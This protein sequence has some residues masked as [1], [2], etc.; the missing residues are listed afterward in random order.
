MNEKHINMVK[1]DFVRVINSRFQKR[2]GEQSTPKAVTS[3]GG[4]SAHQLSINQKERVVDPEPSSDHS[5]IT[6]MD[7]GFCH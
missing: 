3:L 6:S 2:F 5:L 7:R 4:S 1:R